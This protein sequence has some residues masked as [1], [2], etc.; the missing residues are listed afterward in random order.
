[1]HRYAGDIYAS[2]GWVLAPA[3]HSPERAG[4]PSQSADQV[5]SGGQVLARLGPVWGWDGADGTRGESIAA[6]HDRRAGTH[7]TRRGR[8]VVILL[9]TFLVVVA[10]GAG[11]VS[12]APARTAPSPTVLVQ[13]GDTLWSIAARVAAGGD[14]RATVEQITALNGVA[15]QTLLPGERLVVPDR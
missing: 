5:P 1:M 9:L 7:L 11:R 4:R 15:A 10:F 8:L 12:A 6:S 14:V 13:S 2:N 3:P